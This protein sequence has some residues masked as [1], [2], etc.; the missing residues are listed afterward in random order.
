MKYA[1]IARSMGTRLRNARLGLA[2]DDAFAML[3]ATYPGVDPYMLA[4]ANEKFEGEVPDLVCS[5]LA[6]AS[7]AMVEV[8]YE[9]GLDISECFASQSS[10]AWAGGV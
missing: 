2:S 5:L 9:M 4:I 3:C 7:D 8:A 6:R 10:P 1:K